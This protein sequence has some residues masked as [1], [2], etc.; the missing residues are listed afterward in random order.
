[1]TIDSGDNP[2]LQ[3]RFHIP[4]DRIQASD[5]Q[6]AIKRLL[7]DARAGVESIAGEPAPR[8]FDNTMR[9]LDRLTEPLDY[10][11]SVVRHL[12][13]V[14]TTPELRTAYNAVQPEVSGFYS[15]IPLHAGLWNVLREYAST[16]EAAG[17]RGERRRYLHKTL[18]TFRRHG[19][20]LNPDGKKRLEEI[21]IELTQITTRFSQHVLDSTNAFELLITD[22]ARLAG[23][24]QSALDA[25]RESAER[26]GKTGWRFT[27]Q[28][29]DY[30]ALLTYLD[31]RD[32]RRQVYE[33]NSVRATEGAWDNRPLIVRILEQRRAKARL[34]GFADFAD[35]ALE[36]RMAHRGERALEFLQDL[37]AKTEPRFGQENR[38]L[39]EFRRST[40][41]AMAGAAR[42]RWVRGTWPITPRSSARRS[43]ISMKRRC[44]RIFKPARSRPGCLSSP[45]A[46]TAFAWRSG[47]ACRFGTRR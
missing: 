37:R 25:A 45:A 22:E 3:I 18:D 23:L 11:Q 1:M 34:L 19:S 30:F 43:T 28:A 8:T 29:P 32:I 24:L 44:G 40:D 42:T 47:P 27:L 14:A 31:D 15:G 39:E 6:P 20:E 17:L 46:S 2:L 36:D 16:E 41:G 26:K 33:A 21:D 7:V 9:P 4:F 5:V 38:E 13:A 35:F 10:A 12:E